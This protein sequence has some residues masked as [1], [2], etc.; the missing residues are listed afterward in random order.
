MEIKVKYKHIAFYGVWASWLQN[1]D[2]FMVF[3]QMNCLCLYWTLFCKH[4]ILRSLNEKLIGAIKEMCFFWYEEKSTPL[5]NTVFDN[6][7]QIRTYE[8]GH[9]IDQQFA[10][11]AQLREI[12]KADALRS[13][14][15]GSTN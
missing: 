15:G 8:G 1:Q 14:G 9:N 7:I 12:A 2:I 6:H 10:V 13:F 4:Y 11:T 3:L 5:L